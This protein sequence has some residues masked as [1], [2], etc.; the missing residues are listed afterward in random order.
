MGACCLGLKCAVVPACACA[1]A[2]GHFFGIGT[3]CGRAM[4]ESHY[5]LKNDIACCYQLA[6][7]C[8][9][10]R[11]T[12]LVITI[13]DTVG[14]TKQN[15]CIGNITGSYTLTLKQD[16]GFTYIPNCGEYIGRGTATVPC[17]TIDPPLHA[18]GT[19][20][21]VAD[22]VFSVVNSSPR[23][24]AVIQA[25]GQPGSWSPNG[26][27]TFVTGNGA[28]PCSVAEE[29]SAAQGCYSGTTQL[30]RYVSASS[31]CASRYV[32]AGTIT[33]ALA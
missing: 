12:Q 19:V 17:M 31:V 29:W 2:G 33:V 8:V 5:Q 11:P 26:T 9:S 18:E 22:L 28:P 16:Q 27:G 30:Y 10:G 23:W 3:T 7:G 14:L 24:Y 1:K 20:S 4:P 32:P 25:T 6:Q 21:F 13:S 15:Q